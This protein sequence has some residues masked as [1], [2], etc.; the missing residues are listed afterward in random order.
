MLKA[1]D[2]TLGTYAAS[3]Y[4]DAGLS[5]CVRSV[6][7]IVRGTHGVDLLDI[8]ML[9]RDGTRRNIAAEAV[10]C[11]PMLSQNWGLLRAQGVEL[12]GPI[13]ELRS[14]LAVSPLGVRAIRNQLIPIRMPAPVEN[15]YNA[16]DSRDVVSVYPLDDRNFPSSPAIENYGSVRNSTPNRHGIVGYLGDGT[17]ARKIIQHLT[18]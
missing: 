11:C 17:V 12:P 5:N 3:A 8:A 4:A 14:N 6:R 15:W 7:D 2:P 18:Q 16:F 9:T 1:I 10:P 13:A